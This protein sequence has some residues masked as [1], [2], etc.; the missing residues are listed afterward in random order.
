MIM[1]VIIFIYKALNQ[2]QKLAFYSHLKNSIR[3][4]CYQTKTYLL[5]NKYFNV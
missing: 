3:I 4:L 1:L 2:D 5:M